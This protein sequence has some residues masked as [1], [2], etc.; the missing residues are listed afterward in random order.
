MADSRK[1]A[2]VSSRTT[3]PD[4]WDAGLHAESEAGPIDVGL[5]V[6][7]SAVGV[8]VDAPGIGVLKLA[9]DLTPEGT[10]RLSRASRKLSD[11]RDAALVAIDES[12]V[13][14]LEGALARLQKTHDELTGTLTTERDEA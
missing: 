10:T 14:Q 13:L 3:A 2:D 5:S 8:I 12:K 1:R 6:E 11:G 4:A 7:P 9:F